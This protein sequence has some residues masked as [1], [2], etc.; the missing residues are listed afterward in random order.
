MCSEMREE[1]ILNRA[2]FYIGLQNKVLVMWRDSV[3][4]GDIKR[5]ERLRLFMRSLVSHVD[6]LH[7]RF[8]LI[9]GW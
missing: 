3:A 5:A 7:H 1:N 2:G 9:K 6:I 8:D 4:S